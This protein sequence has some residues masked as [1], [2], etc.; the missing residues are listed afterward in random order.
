[1]QRYAICLKATPQPNGS[2]KIEPHNCTAKNLCLCRGIAQTQTILVQRLLGTNKKAEPQ[3]F[4]WSLFQEK[5][6]TVED[7][8]EQIHR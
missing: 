2:I 4:L 7:A 6:W 8:P 3:V 1:M 5:G